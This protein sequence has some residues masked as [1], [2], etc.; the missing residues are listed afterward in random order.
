VPTITAAHRSELALIEPFVIGQQSCAAARSTDEPLPTIAT[1]GA[2]ALVQ[3]FVVKYYGS[4]NHANSLELP[5]DTVTSKDRFLLVEPVSG[6]V[7]AELDILLRMLQPHE[8]ALAMSFPESYKFYGNREQQ[9]K[10]IGNAV[11][12]ELARA[13]CR[14][15]LK[16]VVL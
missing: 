16:A 10:Q 6:K 2:I 5:L 13:H 7:V 9:I 14:E 4:A 12:C 1:D 8:L 3:P 11:P 15:L